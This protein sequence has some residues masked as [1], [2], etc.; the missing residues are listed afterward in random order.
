MGD[1]ASHVKLAKEKAEAALEEFAKH[2]YSVA[3]DL[4][5]KACEQAVQA[6]LGPHWHA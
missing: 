5:Y 1:F 2:R 6:E 3:S 4:A